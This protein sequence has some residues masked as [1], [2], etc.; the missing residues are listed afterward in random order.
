MTTDNSTKANILWVAIDIAKASNDILVE[1]PNGKKKTFK[2][3]NRMEDYLQF[4]DYIKSFEVDC[5]A[6]FEATADYHR[7]FAFHLQKA[8]VQVKLISS[9]SAAKTREALYNSWDK[10]DRKDAQVILHLLKTGCTQKFYDPLL[11]NIND[12][13]EIAKTYHQISMRKV[14]IQHSIMNHYLPLYFPE[15]EKYFHSSRAKWFTSILHRFPTPAS[16]T[17][18]TFDDFVDAAWDVSGRKVNK[19]GWLFDLYE[20][21][22]MS[23]GLPVDINSQAVAM[24]RL[25]LQEHQ[26]LCQHMKDIEK[27]AEQMLSTNNDY[28]LLKSIPGIG[29]IIALII[30]SE[31]G[32]LKRFKH[33]RQFLKF[34]GFDLFTHQSGCFRGQS[35]LSKFGNAR[36]R[37][38]FWLAGTVAIRMAE[39]TFRAKFENYIKQDPTN[40][41]RKRKGYTA[42]AAKMARV[43]Y[44]VVKSQIQYRCYH[45][46]VLPSGRIASVGP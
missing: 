18:Y 23:I 1:L 43:A 20:T 34:C 25:I 3:V 45:E 46:S 36:L 19:K 44:G 38:A 39:N 17:Q 21:A 42:V 32:D 15:V 40:K 26:N 5:I 22:K 7:A 12:I 29:P 9:F 41:D 31:A 33:Y 8:G 27:N 4:I 13:Q 30:L 14:R 6:G 16:I 35:K 11:E 2:V 24:F 28:H 10:N 37:Y